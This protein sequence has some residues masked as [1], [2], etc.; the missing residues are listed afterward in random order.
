M[1]EL[2]GIVKPTTVYVKERK[3][4][5]QLLQELN[6]STDHVVLVEGR[7]LS[8]DDFID[9]DDTIIILPLIAGG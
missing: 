9:P 8:L 3:T 6:L 7:R 5:V 4:V 2:Q 1:A